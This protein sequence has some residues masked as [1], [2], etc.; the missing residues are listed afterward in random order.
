VG[1]PSNLKDFKTQLKNTSKTNIYTSFFI[2]TDPIKNEYAA[3]LNVMQQYYLPLKLGYVDPVEGLAT[4]KEKLKAA[5]VEKVQAEIQKQLDE[6][7][8]NN[9]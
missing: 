8:K 9:K 5:G 2:N 1:S 7:M 6:F 4:L 3:V